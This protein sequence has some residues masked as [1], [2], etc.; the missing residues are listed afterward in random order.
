MSHYLECGTRLVIKKTIHIFRN[1]QMA[2]GGMDATTKMALATSKSLQGKTWTPL[3]LEKAIDTLSKEMKL[4]V[5][6]P[7]AMVRFRQTLAVS[8]LFKVI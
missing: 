2:F 6:A 3:T 4:P 7:G 8:F 5:E 1:A